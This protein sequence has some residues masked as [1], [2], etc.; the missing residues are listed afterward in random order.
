MKVAL[1]SLGCAKNLVNTEQM[2]ALCRDAGY[3]LLEA[4]AGADAV[5]MSTVPEVLTAAHAGMD[6]FGLSFCVNMAAGRAGG[7]KHLDFT[8]TSIENFTVLVS[9]MIAA[10]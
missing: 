4:P 2:M 8:K 3:T 7:I 5:G 10:L 1:I 6:I 9:G